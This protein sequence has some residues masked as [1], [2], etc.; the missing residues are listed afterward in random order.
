MRTHRNRREKRTPAQQELVDAT[1]DNKVS[2]DEI[3]AACLRRMPSGCTR[4]RSGWSRCSQAMVRRRWRPASSTWAARRRAPSLRCAAIRT[5]RATKCG[6]GFLTALGG[7]DIPEPPLHATIDAAP[8]ALAEWIAS[9]DNPLFARVMV[10]RIW[11]YHFGAGLVK[12]PSD[13]GTRG[14]QPSHPEL[15]DWL[16]T[17]FA[18]REVVDQGDA[19]A[20]HDVGRV[21]AQR[22]S[23]REARRQ[24]DPENMLLSHMNRRRLAGGRDS[25][26]ACCR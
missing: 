6:P 14:G 10:N 21:P 8:K 7:G 1:E 18:A 26:C 17:E 25:R 9:P 3:R 2:D 4:S 19:Q 5:L 11:Q 16:A 20:D 23:R 12:T 22:E 15:L 24:Q 13:F